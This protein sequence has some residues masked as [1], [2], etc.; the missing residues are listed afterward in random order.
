M[1]T[2]INTYAEKHSADELIPLYTADQVAAYLHVHRNT[3]YR[4][5]REGRLR[6]VRIGQ[7]YRFT[8]DNVNDFVA[9]CMVDNS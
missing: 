3:V 2:N 4:Y 1:E 5:L 6:G 7:C 8:P 9:S